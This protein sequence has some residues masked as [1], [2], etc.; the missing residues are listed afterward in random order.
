MWVT[1]K[2]ENRSL[3]LRLV[4]QQRAKVQFKWKSF[5]YFDDRIFLC[6]R[7]ILFFFLLF[8]FVIVVVF[9]VLFVCLFMRWTKNRKQ[10]SLKYTKPPH[11]IPVSIGIFESNSSIFAI[12]SNSNDSIC[13]CTLCGSSAASM[14]CCCCCCYSHWLFVYKFLNCSMCFAPH[15]G[16]QLSYVKMREK[17]CPTDGKKCR[18]IYFT[19][20]DR[21]IAPYRI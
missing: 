9:F 6:F 4:F 17:I 19:L 14:N 1:L 12:I 20:W 5:I 11:Q 3:R 10:T 7:F 16:A 13:Q 18:R 2:T 8:L 21:L 15:S